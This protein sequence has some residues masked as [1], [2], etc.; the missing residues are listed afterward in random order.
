MMKD[1]NSSNNNQVLEFDIDKLPNHK[2]RQLER[3]VN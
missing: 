3:Y 2:L 1:M